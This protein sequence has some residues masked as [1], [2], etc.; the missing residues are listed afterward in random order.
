MSGPAV[1]AGPWRFHQRSTDEAH[2]GSVYAEPLPGQAY[3][4][5]MQPK[6]V[7]NEQWAVDAAI[8]AEA[9]TVYTDTG[10]TPRQLMEQR[11]ELLEALKR[12]RLD[13]VNLLEDGRDRIIAL[14]GTCDPVDVMEARSPAIR[15]ANAAIAS[16]TSAKGGAK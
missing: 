2:N 1:T 9:G 7:S 11:D 15:S 4:V 14:G 12:L 6:Y 8:L 5:A 13:Y 3:A 16:A 10:L